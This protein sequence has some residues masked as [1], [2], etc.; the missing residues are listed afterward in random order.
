MAPFY[1]DRPLNFAHR[2]ASSQAPA[3]TLAAFL[4]AAELGADGIEL[5]VHQSRDGEVVVIHDFTLQATTDGWGV[6]EDRTLAELRQLDAGSWFAPAF[7]GQHIPTLQEVI[8]A[9]GGNLLLNIELK[10]KSLRDDGLAAAV[11]RIIE[12]NGLVDRALVSS[13]N[14]LALWRVRRLNPRILIGLLYAPHLPVLLRRPWLRSL[15]RPDSLHPHHT[16]VDGGYVR[17]IQA[18]GFRLHTW[19]VDEAEEMQRLM[20]WGVD[21]IITNRPHLLR[22]VLL[23]GE[24]EQQVSSRR[25]P[26]MSG[27]EGG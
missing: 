24:G 11:V 7:A 25:L 15:I 9:G 18:Q 8:D 14:P 27:F 4:L 6:V 1:L 16:V 22:Q 17:W 12:G 20:Q 19:T 5:D 23:A 21:A 10:T 3:N 26:S 2:G 13:F